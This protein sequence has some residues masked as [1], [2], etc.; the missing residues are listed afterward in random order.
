MFILFPYIHIQ[1]Q[2]QSWKV[3]QAP[4]RLMLMNPADAAEHH[5]AQGDQIIRVQIHVNSYKYF[6][7]F[8]V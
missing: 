1:I 7:K 8:Y 3:D 2:F 6:L 4:Q 5:H